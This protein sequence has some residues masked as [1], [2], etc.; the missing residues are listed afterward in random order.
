MEEKQFMQ[1]VWDVLRGNTI[2]I[3][4][5]QFNE[6]YGDLFVEID[7]DNGE[8]RL[9]DDHNEWRLMLQKTWCDETQLD[10]RVVV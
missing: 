3:T 8:I 1:D 4:Q 2:Y 10:C 7:C 6:K 9:A 5:E